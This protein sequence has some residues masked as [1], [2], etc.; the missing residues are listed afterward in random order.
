MIKIWTS[1]KYMYFV[2]VFAVA[3][4]LLVASCS[5]NKL[6]KQMNLFS[7]LGF[8]PSML[9]RSSPHLGQESAPISLFSF[10]APPNSS[11]LCHANHT[12]IRHKHFSS[13]PACW[14]VS[15]ARSFGK[16]QPS[17]TAFFWE[18]TFLCTGSQRFLFLFS[19]HSEECVFDSGSCCS[20]ST[21]AANISGL[22][23][24]RPASL[25]QAADRFS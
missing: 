25:W 22:S 10:S 20:A 4:I 5:L 2:H 19:W 17:H 7:R 1:T 9:G 11:C 23:C 8:P 18:P 14:A 21:N 16:T 24:N 15:S 6:S 13:F 12:C 3:L